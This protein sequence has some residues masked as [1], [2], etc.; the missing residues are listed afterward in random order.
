MVWVCTVCILLFV[1]Y[2]LWYGEIDDKRFYIYGDA[3][4]SKGCNVRVQGQV[5]RMEQKSASCYLYLRDVSVTS[6]LS[7]V[8]HTH[9]SKLILSCSEMPDLLPGYQIE[10]EG[11]LCDFET[12]T[13]PGQFDAKAYYRERGYYYILYEKNYTVVSAREDPYRTALLSLKQR[14]QSVIQKSLP[15]SQVGIVQTMLL[16]DKSALDRDVRQLY[17][18]NGIGHLLAISGLHITILCM[19]FY[20]LLLS[21]RFPRMAA[22]PL[23]VVMLW[24][25]GEMTGF[26]VSTNRAILMMV[27]YLFAGVLG[28]SY[29]LLSAMA[30]SALLILLQKPF[31]VTSC[32]FL[33]SYAAVM[34]VG[35][36]H[37]V[38]QECV[39]GDK[40][41][42][43]S[44]KRRMHR[45]EREYK[46]AG[47]LGQ[48][49]WW[50]ITV[51]E[52]MIQSLLM[53]V[54][55]QITTLPLMLYFYYEVPTYG[56]LLN[57]LALPL[58]SFLIILAASA[59]LVGLFLPLVAKF[60]FGTVSLILSFYELLC[61]LFLKLPMPITLSG[62]PSS[63][64]LVGYILLAA[65]AVCLWQAF[66]ARRIPLYLWTI[67]TIILVLPPLIPSF[68]ITFLDVGQGDGI[69][70]HTPDDVTILIDGGSSS[71]KQVGEYRI[72]PFLKYHGIGQI[73]YMIM[74]HADEDHISG[75]RELLEN[76][77][78]PGEIRIQNL[79]LPEPAEEYQQE[80]GY[81]QMLGLAQA[82][83]IPVA[84][85]HS[86]DRLTIQDLDVLCLHPDAGFDGG[87]ANAYSTSLSISWRELY[88][89]LCG[90][91]EKTGEDAVTSRLNT[92]LS[93]NDNAQSG[94]NILSTKNDNVQI[95]LQD[96][97]D[98][99]DILKVSHHGS[100]NSTSDEFLEMVS[101]EVSIISCGRDNRYG[102]PHQ[103]LLERLAQTN[104]RILRTDTQGAIKVTF[105]YSF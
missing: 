85:I 69:V 37:P 88:F 65:A 44:R 91:L 42:R 35:L 101:P 10:A 96:I 87:S 78:K 47:W 80:E 104:T 2:R 81:Q 68:S 15:Q 92:Q 74:S 17:Q 76:Q 97:P 84:Y 23:T 79:I 51:R 8:N 72:K 29:D 86:G 46:A 45:M 64:R 49:R 105:T 26:S 4:G 48:L 24:S 103:E 21:L 70:I 30:C 77:G 54:S 28:R 14:L 61:S 83:D 67:G 38:L 5:D 20:Q 98:H 7:G 40:E 62:R 9:L 102:H 58:A 3:L 60:L 6:S 27:L 34:G 39:L 33:L 99:Y 41:Q 22:V 13:N 36:V 52:G 50:I 16:G 1:L 89:L 11:N 95:R 63:V 100:K 32:S 57:I 82:A 18:Q 75:Q 90:D 31:A 59:S 94:Q 12:A 43:R 53:S 66:R 25:Y 73:D 55:I 19:A 56:L 71:E 93:E